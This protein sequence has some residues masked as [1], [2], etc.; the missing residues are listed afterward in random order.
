MSAG[1]AAAA[2]AAA[3]RRQEQEEEEMTFMNTDPSGAFEYKIIRSATN[4]FKT[5][6]FFQHTLQEEAQAG[7]ELVEKLDNGRVRLRRSIDWRKKDG[8]LVQL[9]Q[10]PYRTHVGMSEVKLIFVVLGS[11]FGTLFL[12]FAVVFLLTR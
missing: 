2:A 7:W 3:K 6:A 9:G 1:G 11:I 5:P 8:D 10:D 12:I 4:A